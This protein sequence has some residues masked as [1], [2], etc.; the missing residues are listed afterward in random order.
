MVPKA[1]A[2]TGATGSGT[3]GWHVDESN[4]EARDSS[5][6]C[7]NSS[8]LNFLDLLP[9]PSAAPAKMA[10]GAVSA[11]L[12]AGRLAHTNKDNLSNSKDTTGGDG[13]PK[14]Q[15]KLEVIE[16]AKKHFAE[17]DANR[18][19]FMSAKELARQVESPQIK[20]ALAQT[21]AVLY[22]MSS[23][24]DF[25][26]DEDSPF[27]GFAGI[28]MSDLGKVEEVIKA[29]QRN[30][31]DN[32]YSARFLEVAD[33]NGN[34]KLSEAEL[35][36]AAGNDNLPE[37]VKKLL[38]YFLKNQDRLDEVEIT[39]VL[40]FYSS[41]SLGDKTDAK[42]SKMDFLI[43]KTWENQIEDPN[44][45]A[46]EMDEKGV[47]MYGIQQGIMGDC[48]FVASIAA[49]AQMSPE[50]IKQMI[51]DNKNGTYTVTFPGAKDEPIT[52][53]APTEAER[54]LYN[55]SS[56][57]GVWGSILEK[58]YGAYCGKDFTRRT[59][60]NWTGGLTT[61]EGADGGGVFL[62]KLMRLLTGEGADSDLQWITRKSVTKSKLM[63]HVG[64][65]DK[66]PVVAWQKPFR[67]YGLT[68]VTNHVYSVIDYDPNGE[69]GGTVTLY[70]PWG[71]KEDI[72]FKQFR[73]RFMSVTYRDR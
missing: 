29:K 43:R 15:S 5:V 3:L 56:E 70:N 53:S 71:H 32:P 72:S 65:Q 58:A 16:L 30:A 1:A 18:D 39:D 50:T 52:V 68:T 28:S 36:E 4:D 17:F 12:A 22:G 69:D 31:T 66:V 37:D 62:G 10:A 59:P 8:S 61:T 23:K 67:N 13:K 38:D 54:G 44:L 42:L 64:V 35:K 27:G 57:Y 2:F 19:G 21:I 25:S 11:G 9:I 55:G 60:L 47:S 46:Q 7:K 6:D 40:H 41:Q 24:L 20:G 49:V 63:E 73:R 51:V 48:Y 33:K 45:Y 14:L 26:A 34:G